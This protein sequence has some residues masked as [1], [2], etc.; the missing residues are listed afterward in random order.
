MSSSLFICSISAFASFQ[1]ASAFDFRASSV[2]F[3]ELRPC[4][5]RYSRYVCTVGRRS[6]RLPCPTCLY[7]KSPWSE[8]WR[9]LSPDMFKNFATKDV[10]TKFSFP[11]SISMFTKP[12]PKK[13]LSIFGKRWGSGDPHFTKA[14]PQNLFGD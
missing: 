8:I 14:A 1:S 13:T 2:I 11:G 7:S 10:G 4:F 3:D 12:N 9:T 5:F 6:Y